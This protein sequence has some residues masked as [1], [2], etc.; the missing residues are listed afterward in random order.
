MRQLTCIV[1]APLAGM[2]LERVLH[3]PAPVG[4]VNAG[5]TVCVL[6]VPDDFDENTL[7]PGWQVR[8]FT[9]PGGDHAG[10]AVLA[11]VQPFGLTVADVPI[12]MG[13]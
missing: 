3:P 12:P 8:G 10:R 9:V 5:K 1:P 4:A 6:P 13:W 2:L 7:P 11:D